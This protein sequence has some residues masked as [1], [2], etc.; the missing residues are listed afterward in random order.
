LSKEENNSRSVKSSHVNFVDISDDISTDESFSQL[1]DNGIIDRN[2]I[3]LDSSPKV[4]IGPGAAPIDVPVVSTILTPADPP[5]FNLPPP[6]QNSPT[7]SPTLWL[8]N[9]N[10]Q[11]EEHKSFQ[12]YEVEGKSAPVERTED[13]RERSENNGVGNEGN[14]ERRNKVL[15]NFGQIR[16][17][18]QLQYRKFDAPILKK[19]NEL[20]TVRNYYETFEVDFC[21]SVGHSQR[22]LEKVCCFFLFF[23]FFFFFFRFFLWFF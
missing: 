5:V 14:S 9:R 13:S 12:G 22:Y 21:G 4:D 1:L 16:P 19:L 15:D 20:V 17:I 11:N 8:N 2:I 23:F 6:A 18:G 10:G 7:Q 3:S